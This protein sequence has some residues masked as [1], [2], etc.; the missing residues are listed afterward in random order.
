MALSKRHVFTSESVTEGHPDKVADQISDAVL[1]AI[2]AND[3]GGRVACETLVT[4]GMAG[5]AG[6]I[7]TKTYVHS[8]DIV[9]KTVEGIGYTDAS[10]GFDRRITT[11]DTRATLLMPILLAHRIT[12][13]LAKVRKGL[14]APKIDGPRDGKIAGS[15]ETRATGAAVRTVVVSTQHAERNGRRVLGNGTIRQTVTRPS[16]RCWPPRGSSTGGSGSHQSHRAIRGRRPHGDA[17]SPAGKSSCPTAAWP[18]TV[19]GAFRAG[20]HESGSPAAYAARRVAKN[21][22]ALLARRCE[23]QVAR[24]RCGGAGFDHGGHVPHRRAARSPAGADRPRRVRS[25]APRHH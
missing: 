13:R 23:V 25:Q 17:G 11:G 5:V 16:R 12:E 8:P 1:D 24:H 19:A 14:T 3:P 21:T 20:I 2:R 22:V 4:T 7:S 6:E 10:F 9:R 18:V 15:V